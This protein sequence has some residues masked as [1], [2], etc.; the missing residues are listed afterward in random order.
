MSTIANADMARAWEEEGAHW[1]E[2][3]ER[4]EATGPRQWQRLVATGL[5]SAT[6]AVLDIGCGTGKSTRDAAR[7]AARG[8]ALGVDLAAPMIARAR[9]LAAAQGVANASF[10]QADAQVHPFDAESFDVAISNFGAMFFADPVAAFANVARALRP[11]GGL[12]LLTWR[13]LA[14]NE[15]VTALRAALARGRQL[16]EPSPGVPGP[17]QLVDDDQVRQILTAAGFVAVELQTVDEPVHFGADAD[18]AFAFAR[19]MGIVRG[20]TQDLDEP[21][22]RQALEDLHATLAAHETEE[23]VLL[24][25]SAWLTTA[26]RG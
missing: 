13:D 21:E 18:D 22:R 10:L 19:T 15:W 6:D 24:G 12:G 9:E 25:S 26:R 2:H 4:Y 3:A 23:G 7:L 14:R 16:P 8:E 20:L 5:I 1:A 11:G 17:F